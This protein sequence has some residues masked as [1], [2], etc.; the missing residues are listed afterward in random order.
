MYA[1]IE[2]GGKQ[3][4]AEPGAILQIETLHAEVGDTV[5]LK[6]VRFLAGDAGTTIGQP[7]IQDAHVKAT[8][9]RN[10]RTRSILVFKKKRR[11]NY[12]KSRGHRQEFTQVRIDE[13]VTG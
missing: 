12:R 9:I 13:I 6:P 3:Y 1:I 8:V 11:K 5:E 2:T 4:R 10:G 7:V